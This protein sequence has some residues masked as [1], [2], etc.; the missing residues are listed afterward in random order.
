MESSRGDERVAP[1]GGEMPVLKGRLPFRLGTTSYI[2]PADILPNVRFLAGLVDDVELV[3]F[4]SDEISNLPEPDVV[5]DLH[6]LADEHDLTY[7]VHL[8]LDANLGHPMGAERRR[9]VRKCLRVIELTSPLRPFA[10]V[11][12]ILREGEQDQEAWRR[13]VRRSIESLLEAGIGRRQVCVETLDYDFS[14][15]APVVSD[16][17]LAVCVDVG[18]LLLR[19][20][21]PNTVLAQHLG[22]TRVVHLHG[23][24]DGRDHLPVDVLDEALLG[25]MLRLIEQADGERVVTLE[26]FGQEQ[27]FRSLVAVQEAFS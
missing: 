10:Y 8:P 24:R 20:E 22:R 12:H 2:K 6:L 13:A 3:L 25:E 23:V 9:S 5:T 19:E 27:L 11:A 15:I 16:C 17:G 26:V 4:E 1:E 14:L 7:T 18:H 21:D